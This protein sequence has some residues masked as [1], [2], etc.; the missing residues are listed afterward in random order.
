MADEYMVLGKALPR[1]GAINVVTGA[2]TYI[3]DL[4]IPRM[5]RT[6]ILRSP[7]AHANITSID[8]SKAEALP[9]VA[10]VLTY[11]NIPAD[12]PDGFGQRSHIHIL[13]STVRF[14]GDPVAVVAAETDQI[15][16]DA[17]SLI[18]VE[19]EKLD[20]VFTTEDAIN[21]DAPV[22]HQA[23][24]GNIDPEDA[25][26][27]GDVDA[28]FAEADT[29][30]TEASLS[31]SD[32]PAVNYVEDSGTIAWWEGDKV[33]V[34]R[35]TNN[36]PGMVG[37]GAQFT[38]LPETNIRALS[39]RYVGG[40]SNWKDWAVKDLEFSVA[41]AKITG[42]PVAVFINKEE[43]YLQYHKERASAHVKL[44][45]KKDG[46]AVAIDGEATGD[47]TAYNYTADAIELVTS[48]VTQ[49]NVPNMRFKQLQTVFT[50][51]PPGGGC[52]GWIYMEGHW[53]FAPVFMQAMESI[54][55][56]P[57][58]FYMKN[59]LKPGDSYF[60]GG[61]SFDCYCEPIRNA[62]QQAAQQ[63][64]WAGKWKGWRTPTATNSNKVRGVGLGWGGHCLGNFNSFTATVAL[65][66]DGKVTVTPAED[67]MGNGNRANLHKFAAEVLKVPIDTVTG[68]PADSSAQPYYGWTV[69]DGTLAMGRAILRAAEDVRAKLL[70]KAADK[71]GVSA[72]DLDTRE[73]VVFVSD[74]P[75]QKLAWSE[76]IDAEKSIIGTGENQAD[77]GSEPTVLCCF[78]EVEVDTDTGDC[79]LVDAV[80]ATDVGKVVSPQDCA[81]QTVWSLICDGTRET[82]VLDKATGRVLNPNYLD[83][84]SRTFADLPDFQTVLGETP[85]PGAPFGARAL[86]E[87]IGVPLTP[88]VVMAVYNATGQMLSLPLTPD[89]IL[90]A[91][92]K[93]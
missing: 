71:M 82:Y 47:A 19:Y 1:P 68:P 55:I 6:R 72:E 44:G 78:A 17:L 67:E 74:N 13:N 70:A 90:A 38:G 20:A 37:R 16:E 41:L 26:S 5:L 3:R 39:P 30:V 76:I 85:A 58:D 32:I 34:I 56:N 64:D 29:V 40:C 59:A 27:F 65:S 42:R 53:L 89:K 54:D 80:Y 88:A 84:K 33:N 83:L 9:G 75:E 52:R 2:A 79:Q 92:G 43:Q 45:L 35:T 7:H 8:T 25:Y 15:A 23:F 61:R 81:Q 63:F 36:S 77:I 69:C 18:E 14:V 28:A 49:A 51:T 57:L 10:A 24:P 60:F 62:A 31:M 46:T 21:P 22:L 48:L 91:L 4:K 73:R 93:A 87:P 11:Q 66:F 50:N 12:W 86:A